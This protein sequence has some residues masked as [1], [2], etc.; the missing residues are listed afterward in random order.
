MK[1]YAFSC[2]RVTKFQNG[3][4][5]TDIVKL[6]V[7][8]LTL[9]EKSIMSTQETGGGLSKWQIAALIGAP[10]AAACILGAFYYWRSSRSSE[11]TDGEKGEGDTSTGAS[12]VPR[13]EAPEGEENM[14]CVRKVTCQ[15]NIS[16]S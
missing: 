13:N 12:D 10:V 6:K 8:L 11:Q 4:E 7:C 15:K 16:F 2:T 1:I 5:G 9:S 14:V 3:S